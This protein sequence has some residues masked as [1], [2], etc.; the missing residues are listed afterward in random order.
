MK[1]WGQT[2]LAE[3]DNGLAEHTA[4]EGQEIE[5]EIERHDEGL[6]DATVTSGFSET[7][8]FS[9]DKYPELY[10]KSKDVVRIRKEG[11]L[12]IVKDDTVRRP[13][14]SASANLA[15]PHLYPHGEMSPLD[16]AAWSISSKKASTV[17][18]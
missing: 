7:H 9:F 16:F 6:T 1:V 4:V 5:E 2:E 18:T 15:F 13:T 8:V 11:K 3:V 12:E 14:Y 17:R 10:L